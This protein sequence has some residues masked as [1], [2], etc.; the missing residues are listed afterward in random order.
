[1]SRSKAS[2]LGRWLPGLVISTIAILLLIRFTRWSEILETFSQIK[3]NWLLPALVFFIL[4]VGLRALAWMILLQKK[5]S[6]GRVFVTLNEGYLLN[7]IFPFRLGELGRAFLLSE[8]ANLSGFFVLSTIVI[9]RTYDLAIAAGLFLATLPNI[10]ELENSQPIAVSVLVL[11]TIGLF[12]MFIIARNR[13]WINN[14]LDNINIG[15]LGI[16]E[17]IIPRVES[18]INGLEVLSNL[19]QFLL[20]FSLLVLSWF[21]GALELVFIS[22]SFGVTLDMWMVA[23]V[24]GVISLGIAIPSA[25]GGLGVYEVAM[26]GSFS[27]LGFSTSAGL[28]IAV[29]THLTS[30][31]ITG[32]IGIYG[33]FRDGESIAGVY[34]KLRRMRFDN[35]SS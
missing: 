6:Y 16:R 10:F 15:S 33:I 24:L 5:A 9:E 13:Q 30:I 29:V 12:T 23:F 26:V 2:T 20:S 17:Y 1:V 18:F 25:P 27:L 34:Q 14:K 4:S 31:I 35:I 22:Q 8:T 7:S 21:F 32:V 11:V 28:A 3:I 19:D